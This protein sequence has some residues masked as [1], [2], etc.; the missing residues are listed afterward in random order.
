MGHSDYSVVHGF[1][2]PSLNPGFAARQLRDP[3][4]K[5]PNLS[6]PQFLYLNNGNN[7]GRKIVTKS[8]RA[9]MCK[10]FKTAPG[11]KQAFSGFC[12][13]EYP[14]EIQSDILMSVHLF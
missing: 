2:P 5:L 7:T 9:T 12:Y 1:K 13:Q 6:T 3:S 10:A 11:P 14:K 4:Y 8:K